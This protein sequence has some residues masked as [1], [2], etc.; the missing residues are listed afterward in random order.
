MHGCNALTNVNKINSFNGFVIRYDKF[1]FLTVG[2]KK[3]GLTF[4]FLYYS[5]FDSWVKKFFMF[6]WL[7]K[8]DRASA[9]DT[10]DPKYFGPSQ[11][12]ESFNVFTSS[13][14]IGGQNSV[15]RKPASSLLLTFK[16]EI[17]FLLKLL[18]Q[19]FVKDCTKD[20]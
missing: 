19:L 2:L 8:Y 1:A 11:T 5:S 15:K 9:F 7:S 4:S 12:F 18:N 17:I 14:L 20:C 16:K 10:I 3:C 13:C 6:K